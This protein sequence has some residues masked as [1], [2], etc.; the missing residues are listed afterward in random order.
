DLVGFFVNTLVLR[1]DT[2]GDPT[3]DELVRRVRENALAAYAHQDLPFEHLVEELNPARSLSH[4][5]L[6]QVMFALQNAPMGDF[7]LPGLT[8]S[9]L[10][11]P[12]GT[13]KFDLG[14]NLVERFGADG[15]PAGLAGAVEYATDLYDRATVDG[16]VA[17]WTRLLEAVVADPRR[18]IG[19]IEVLSA[20]ERR[21]LLEDPND[22]AVPVDAVPLPV[23]FARQART[24]PDAVALVHGDAS[25]TYRELDARA[26]RFAHALVARGIGPE[27]IVAL[28]LPRSVELVVAVLGTM[29]AGAAYLPVDPAYPGSRIAVM[30]DDARP[31]L[32][33][34]DPDL[35]TGTAQHPETAPD[36]AL[37][38]R[39]PAYV[40][41][42][43]G[44][45]GRP[46]G[47]V[48]SHAGI[49]GLVA[50]QVERFAIDA[51][52][53]VLQF[54][55]P[56]F[57]ASVSEMYTALLTGATLVLPPSEPLAALTGPSLGVTHVTLPPSVLAAVPD[58]TLT[59]ATLVVAGEACPPELVAKWAPGRRMI[60]AYGPTETT[61]CATMSAPLTS[62]GQVPP[63]GRPLAHTQVYVL[64]DGLRPVPAGVPG[65]LYVAGGGL[66]RGYLNRPGPTAER[67]VANPYGPPGSRLYR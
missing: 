19:R 12:T 2:S 67:F 15:A 16:L 65:E 21:R 31:A 62:A 25:L 8:V 58:R 53:R 18:P 47:V 40:I 51:D 28:A 37:D 61:V 64:D 50:A 33:V 32:V 1:T 63:I 23:S 5:P 20:D 44:S 55:S 66:A 4:H 22:S 14:F 49:A 30:L 10:P 11:V 46:K 41:Y 35:V 6:F 39:H 36:V 42:T 27:R 29:K 45:T 56:S 9:G 34:D 60:N 54:A 48:V 38:A 17:R 24:T 57:D 59:V 7:D 52:S 26:N 43:S 3:F 13:A